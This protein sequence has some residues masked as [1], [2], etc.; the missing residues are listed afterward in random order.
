MPESFSSSDIDIVVIGKLEDISLHGLSQLLVETGIAEMST[1]KVLE[2]AAVS[3]WFGF[4]RSNHQTSLCDSLCSCLWLYLKVP[5][6]KLTDKLTNVKVDISFNMETGI[7]A[8]ELVKKYVG[9]YPT[10]PKLVFLLKQFLLQR[11]LNEVFTGGVSSYA[12]ILMTIHFLQ[13]SPKYPS[14][15]EFEGSHETFPSL[16]SSAQPS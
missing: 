9:H 13:V 1:I 7:R 14:A 5:I 16:L 8:A 6:V 15:F 11:D 10:L 4:K 12:L 2:K 3:I